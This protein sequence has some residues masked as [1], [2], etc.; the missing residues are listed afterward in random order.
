MMADEQAHPPAQRKRRELT[1]PRPLWLRIHWASVLLTP[2]GL[3]MLGLGVFVEDNDAAAIALI[4]LGP[5]V[6]VAG[7]LL[8]LFESRLLRFALTR[9]GV[10]LELVPPSVEELAQRGLPEPVAETLSE[11]IENV[12]RLLPIEI[13]RRVREEL[14]ARERSK[15]RRTKLAE[16]IVREHEKGP[17]GEGP[18][19]RG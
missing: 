13:D 2:L 16:Q 6:V 3:T 17:E 14:D 7:V 15:Q 19:N 10:S 11:W 12:T 18:A 8:D 4:V 9:F 5:L 1:S